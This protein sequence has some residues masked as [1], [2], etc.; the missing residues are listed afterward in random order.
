MQALSEYQ[1]RHGEEEADYTWDDLKFQWKCLAC[2]KFADEEHCR[3]EQHE[4]KIAWYGAATVRRTRARREAMMSPTP[5]LSPTPTPLSPQVHAFALPAYCL[6]HNEEESMYE[7]DG[8]KWNWRCR[9]CNA[10][11]TEAHC[12]SDRHMKLVL[13][14]LNKFR[15]IGAQRPQITIAQSI[16]A[17]HQQWQKDVRQ[18][19]LDVSTLQRYFNAPIGVPAPVSMFTYSNDPPS[20]SQVVSFWGEVFLFMRNTLHAMLRDGGKYHDLWYFVEREDAWYNAI[21]W[22]DCTPQGTKAEMLHQEWGMWWPAIAVELPN[23]TFDGKHWK[24][25]L[26]S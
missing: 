7:Y 9:L 18:W 12:V 26:V 2:S 17:S 8:L 10:V 15:A 21:V 16:E 5:M 20:Y 1:L 14:G 23:G 13:N 4:R 22:S 6:D 3:S 24:P 25:F 19:G 11:A